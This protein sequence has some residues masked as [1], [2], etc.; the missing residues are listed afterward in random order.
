MFKL[1]RM[2]LGPGAV[3]TKKTDFRK[4]ILKKIFAAKRKI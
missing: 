4:K 2:E 1:L 3:V